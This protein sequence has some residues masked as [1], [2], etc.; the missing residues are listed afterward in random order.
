MAVVDGDRVGRLVFLLVLRHHERELELVQALGCEGN[1]HKATRV[2]DEE[3]HLFRRDF[4]RGDQEIALILAVLVVQHNHELARAVC[5]HD[6]GDVVK[7]AVDRQAP[8]QPSVGRHP[9]EP[10]RR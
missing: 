1:A 6:V 10:R 9:S 2:A 4:A 5:A 7:H 3:R 8:R